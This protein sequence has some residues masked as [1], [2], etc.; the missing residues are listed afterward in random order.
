MQI[1]EGERL[2]IPI[3]NGVQQPG[4]LLF[5][6]RGGIHHFQEILIFTEHT[7]EQ[8]DIVI[9]AVQAVFIPAGLKKASP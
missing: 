3:K 1:V 5:G 2:E 6:Y 9:Q 8:A 4:S 7:P